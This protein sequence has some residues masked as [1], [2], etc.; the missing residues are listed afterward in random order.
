M[1]S[2]SPE[3][4]VVN[5]REF[6]RNLSAY[7]RAAHDGAAIVVTSRGEEMARLGPPVPK[8]AQ[9]HLLIG[10]FQ[11][12]LPAADAIDKTTADLIDALEGEA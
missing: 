5:F 11:G 6:R 12:K 1:P 4:K 7:L 3:E 10:M 8:S 2:E 9:R